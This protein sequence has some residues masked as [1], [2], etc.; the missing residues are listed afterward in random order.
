[1]AD[2]SV[3]CI[4]PAR[5]IVKQKLRKKGLEA[6]RHWS[7]QH[8]RSE[9][10]KAQY[11]RCFAGIAI[12]TALFHTPAGAQGD[13]TFGYD[14]QLDVVYGQGRIAPEGT[15][16]MRDLMMDVYT[17]TAAGDGPWPAVVYIHGGGWHRGGR[18]N[19]PYKLAGVVHSS[20]EDWAR[21]LA[22]NGYKVFVIEYRLAPQNPIPRFVPG[23][24]NTVADVKSV[25]REELMPGLA[26]A[27]TGV[28]LP[29][30]DYTDDGVMV[31]WNAFMA[32]VEDAALALDFVVKHA[33]DLN[34]DPERIAMGGHSAG[35]GISS[36][37][38]LGLATPL[39]AIFS[40]SP[41]EIMFDKDYIAARTDLP[42]VLL[43]FSQ[44]DDEP[45]LA[46]APGL[47]AMLRSSN[48][49]FT[50]G[51]MP[52]YPHFYPYSAASLADDGTR[53]SLGDRGSSSS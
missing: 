39:K 51:W 40:L 13:P 46:T 9:I 24:D 47:I 16:V 43:H 30:L 12:L 38:G 23:Q 53:M 42:A 37:V 8:S 1:V 41:P 45:L 36:G 48:A 52:G 5:A 11:T 49:D 18:R 19:P 14:L 6:V 17:P 7:G 32:G 44:Y 2:V 50:L 26:R 31:I 27:R 28:G 33:M 35:A 3:F 22:A 21:L 10:M 29:M 4:R 20:P 15:E 25:I 34:V